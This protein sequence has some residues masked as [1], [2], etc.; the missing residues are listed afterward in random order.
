MAVLLFA[1]YLYARNGDIEVIHTVFGANLL[2]VARLMTRPN[3][4]G[5]Y[6]LTLADQRGLHNLAEKPGLAAFVQGLYRDHRVKETNLASPQE[7][8]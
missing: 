8:S 7:I 6:E 5:F 2:G 1:T 3:F 4:A